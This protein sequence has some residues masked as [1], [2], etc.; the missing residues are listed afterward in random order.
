MTARRNDLIAAALAILA[1]VLGLAANG[2]AIASI[3]AIVAALY[4]PGRIALRWI[5]PTLTEGALAF[6]LA[7]T[8]SPVVLGVVMTLLMLIGMS[9]YVAAILSMLAVAGAA[10]T[11]FM[12]PAAASESASEP[13]A[14]ER[15]I[16]WPALAVSIVLALAVAWPLLVSNRV[17]ISIHGMLHASILFRV[18]DA[19]AP[20]E[21]PFYADGA[22]RYYWTWHLAG[23]VPVE[24]SGVDP[25]N[26]FAAGNVASALAFVLLLA[27]LGSRLMPDER[28]ARTA[29]A[30]AAFLGF[31]SLNPLGA[32]TFDQVAASLGPRFSTID[33]IAAGEDPI[34]YVQALVMG[35]DERLSATITKFF[36]VSSFPAS[37]ALLAAMWLLALR[38]AHRARI[39][40]F[41]LLALV[42]LGCIALSPITGLTGGLALGIGFL[43]SLLFAVKDTERRNALFSVLGA[44]ALGLIAAFPFVLLSGGDDSGSLKLFAG[45]KKITPGS[46]ALVIAPVLL[47]G[48]RAWFAR[49]RGGG[50]GPRAL[51]LAALV[52]A[53]LALVISFPVASEYKLVREAAPLLGVFA[54]IALVSID[55]KQIRSMTLAVAC[56]VFLP[57]TGIAWNAYRRHAEAALP[58]RFENGAYHLDPERHPIDEVYAWL[59][60]NTPQNAVLLD[61]PLAMPHFAGP[62]HGAEAPALAQ[63]CVYTDRPSYM[64][65]FEPGLRKRLELIRKL[66]DGGVLDR[67]QLG[68][69]DAIDHPVYLLVRAGSQ[70]EAAVARAVI[71]QNRFKRVFKCE[72]GLVFE[73]IRK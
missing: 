8:L 20:P 44:L 58:V 9:S 67:E 39:S 60:A 14:L 49:L 17:R 18:M 29:A 56:G 45:D 26:A 15:P 48:A 43:F 32:F 41:G 13:G 12:M 11:R 55:K 46:L 38:T 68:A 70:N 19:G 5:A 33:K 57:T 34:R 36:N 10:I 52:L 37:L 40:E 7:L 1:I 24:L 21:N 53:P 16:G 25:M 65:D 64:N 4:A 71:L 73:W 59:R 66:F 28:R 47:L 63:R 31:T 61:D 50:D 69:I 35:E 27:L 3:V 62:F 22:L 54:A 23:A 51:A 6:A 72:G 2:S 42:T 30:F